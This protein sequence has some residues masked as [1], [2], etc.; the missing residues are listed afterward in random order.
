MVGKREP[1][2]WGGRAPYGPLPENTEMFS[3]E[4]YIPH[5]PGELSKT[6]LENCF[7][8]FECPTIVLQLY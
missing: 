3:K 5:P 4:G 2:N 7:L 1:E 6:V 8:G